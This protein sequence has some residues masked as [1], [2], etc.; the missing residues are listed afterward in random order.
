MSRKATNE[1][2][3]VRCPSATNLVVDNCVKKSIAECQLY[4]LYRLVEGLV[5]ARP[6]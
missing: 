2:V 4:F 1:Y 3:L 5:L 6:K